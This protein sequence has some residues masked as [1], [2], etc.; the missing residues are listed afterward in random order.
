MLIGFVI[1]ES[2]SDGVVGAGGRMFV[3]AHRNGYG[4]E[5][6]GTVAFDGPDDQDDQLASKVV[7]TVT[8]D[9][10]VFLHK[11][12]ATN[13]DVRDDV[14]IMTDVVTFLEVGRCATTTVTPG[15][16]GCPHEEGVD[17]PE[18]GVCPACPFWE[19]RDRYEIFKALD[20]VPQPKRRWKK[21]RK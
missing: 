1:P 9:D 2:P 3:E 7:A 5:M 8:F 13:G 6:V 20:P 17:Y 18:G 4:E 14:D 15:V 12:F 16:F 21:R 19:G 10:E 11:W